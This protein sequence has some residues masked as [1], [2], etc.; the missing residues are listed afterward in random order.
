MIVHAYIAHR[1][2]EH[3]ESFLPNCIFV[4]DNKRTFR[5]AGLPGKVLRTGMISI[6][7]AVPHIFMRRGGIDLDEVKRF[8]PREKRLPVSILIIHFILVLALIV[9]HHV[10]PRP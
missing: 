1:Y 10:L 3:F 5:H 9:S 2:T 6:V 4:T 8:P 7:L